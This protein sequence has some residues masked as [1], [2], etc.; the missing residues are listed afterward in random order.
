MSFFHLCFSVS[1]SHCRPTECDS[2][3]FLFL[4]LDV[5]IPSGEL[6]GRTF[7]PIL[8]FM[9][10]WGNTKLGDDNL[11]LYCSLGSHRLLCALKAEHWYYM[12]WGTFGNNILHSKS[13]LLELIQIIWYSPHAWCL[14][15]LWNLV[16]WMSLLP[17]STSCQKFS[18]SLN[19]L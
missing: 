9:E 2:Y 19:R 4:C 11:G 8:F 14:L 17:V 13:F 1:L 18:Q 7:E 5:F 15:S 10:K 3:L 6:T 16:S 12:K